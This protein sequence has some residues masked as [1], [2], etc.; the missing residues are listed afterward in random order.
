LRSLRERL[1]AACEPSAELQL[2]C[3]PEGFDASFVIPPSK[4][5]LVINQVP[6]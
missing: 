2:R 4:E 1:R 6:C 5:P 3:G